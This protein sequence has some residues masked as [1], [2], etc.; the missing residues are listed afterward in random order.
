MKITIL[1][2]STILIF[3]CSKKETTP[4][5]IVMD[6]RKTYDVTYE[7]TCIGDKNA[8]FYFTYERPGDLARFTQIIQLD[9]FN[10]SKTWS[11]TFLGDTSYNSNMGKSGSRVYM[12]CKPPYTGTTQNYYSSYVH[13]TVKYNG[14]KLG[15]AEATSD[16]SGIATFTGYLP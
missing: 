12:F 3:S 15:W 5:P 14:I 7:I 1:L 13:L 9:A 8:I 2:I 16:T 11:R 10:S 6:K 4:V